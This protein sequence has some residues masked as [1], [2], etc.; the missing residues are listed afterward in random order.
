[1]SFGNV[2]TYNV[3]KTG[4]G[5]RGWTVAIGQA[6]VHG[7]TTKAK[8]VKWAQRFIRRNEGGTLKVDSK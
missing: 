3:R 8:A 7:P 4:K 2:P 1:M 6:T 5:A